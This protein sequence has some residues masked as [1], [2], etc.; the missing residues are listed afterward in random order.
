MEDDSPNDSNFDP[1]HRFR[2]GW[3]ERILGR[4]E[5]SVQERLELLDVRRSRV[6][7]VVTY[8]AA[9]FLFGG[10]AIFIAILLFP[11]K[12]GFQVPD[13]NGG[14]SVDSLIEAKHLFTALLP[15]ASSI[16]AF[17]FAGRFS[18]KPRNQT[19]D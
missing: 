3:W 6:R 13:E 12:V 9:A 1:A 18:H 8:V 4:P 16:V 15:I 14:I 19:G 2:L 11:D 7:V 17:W 5:L 10:G